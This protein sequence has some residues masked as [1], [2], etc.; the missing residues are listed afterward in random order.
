MAKKALLDAD[1]QLGEKI[2]RSLDAAKFPISVA[3]WILTEEQ[4][5]QLV[6]G[7]PLYESG[8]PGEAY[9]NLIN[10]LRRDDLES[11]DFE[12][13]RL[14]GNRHPFIRELRRLFGKTASVHGMRLGGHHIGGVWLDDAVVYR[15][16]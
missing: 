12:D 3:V 7:T 11:M 8:G 1:V 10:A 14:M 4:G 15:I 5:W 6:I 13:V 2:L 16:K 9:K